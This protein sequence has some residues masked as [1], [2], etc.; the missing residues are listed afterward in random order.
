MGKKLKVIRLFGPPGA[1]KTSSLSESGKK[2][3]SL[4]QD[5]NCLL[6]AS[7]TN[8][9]A[10]EIASRGIPVNP[11]M[12]GTLHA[13]N[14]REMGHPPLVTKPQY[15]QG[16]NEKYPNLALSLEGDSG[17]P[18]HDEPYLSE[19][20]RQ[21]EGGDEEAEGDE[22]MSAADL[23]RHRMVPE[24]AWRGEVAHFYRLWKA[25]KAEIGAIDFTDMV[26]AGLALEGPPMGAQFGIYDEC[27]PYSAQVTLADG[28]QIAIGEIVEKKMSVDVASYSIDEQTVRTNRI[29]GW[30]KVLRRG[31]K[32]L[33]WGDFRATEDH[34]IFTRECGYMRFDTLLSTNG[35]FCVME[36]EYEKLRSHRTT[37]PQGKIDLSRF[38]TWRRFDSQII[39]EEYKR[40]HQVRSWAPATSVSQMEM[41]RTQSLESFSDC[42]PLPHLIWGNG[43]QLFNHESSS[44]HR[45]SFAYG[46]A[47]QRKSGDRTIADPRR[48]ACDG[49]L[50]YGRWID[51]QRQC[52]AQ[53]SSIPNR[54]STAHVQ[55]FYNDQYSNQSEIVAGG[56][57][58]VL[59]SKR[60]ASILFP[61]S[62][63]SPSAFFV[64]NRRRETRNVQRSAEPHRSPFALRCVPNAI[65]QDQFKTHVQQNM[66]GDSTS[67]ICSTIPTE[68]ENQ[69]DEYVYCLE[70][71]NDHNFFAN[72]LLVANCQDFSR[73]EW[74]CILHW[75]Q[76]QDYIMVSGDD[77][78][79]LY[80]WRGAD[81]NTFI[82][83]DVEE[84]R[85]LPQ[86]Y[87]L[88]EAVHSYCER[89]VRQISRR[90]PKEYAPRR[91]SYPNGPVVKGE[92]TYTDASYIHPE[93]IIDIINAA[94]KNK[95]TTMLLTACN[96]H[97][98]YII[99]LLR[100]EGIPFH[101]PWRPTNGRWNPLAA[102]GKKTAL[103]RIS[104]FVAPSRNMRFS[105]T[106]DELKSWV[107]LIE[108]KNVLQHGAKK[109]VQSLPE[110]HTEAPAE[111]LYRIFEKDALTWAQMGDMVWF[112]NHLTDSNK[113]NAALVYAYSIFERTNL[114]NVLPPRVSVGTI[115][116]TKGA[117][118]EI[119]VL[120]PD[121]SPSGYEQYESTG[122]DRDSII[123]QFYVGLSRAREK[124]ILAEAGS[125]RAV[126]WL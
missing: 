11:S 120:F 65:P 1:G 89:W 91:E 63:P 119:V 35:N 36:L 123:R 61:Y 87:R 19:N 41:A 38:V 117:E 125:K 121:L 56:E 112:F 64:Q 67:R 84:P 40:S 76:E 62:P 22:L 24:A 39:G 88:P 66:F 7:L 53:Y 50:V 34:Q 108:G 15:I 101:N 111:L 3:V 116:S 126:M 44:V 82:D 9:A 51:Q 47:T 73:L 104:A 43:V 113:K 26:Q 92:L 30:K 2:A 55:F 106:F 69:E 72:G 17:S 58:A 94:E 109:L 37:H 79:A 105:W 46:W 86:S 118:A 71:A 115:H 74:A 95:Q 18:E 68:T 12:V 48:S 20:R 102:R 114:E 52:A 98:G 49:S 28:S 16:W 33:Q 14:Y 80:V 81:P 31:R 90:Q 8:A 78:Q 85:V 29:I 122:S 83:L 107:P 4:R 13:L 97:L 60:N 23:Y 54:I 93:P 100:K 10:K 77:D 70:V 75:A 57:H 59:F 42:W 27:F 96:Y 5:K 99:A 32:I 45:T 21:E 103:D 25:Y 110:D 6:I 124:L